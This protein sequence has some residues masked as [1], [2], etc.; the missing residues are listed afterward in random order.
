MSNFSEADSPPF[1]ITYLHGFAYRQ[2]SCMLLIP[3]LFL[4]QLLLNLPSFIFR[5]YSK[6]TGNVAPA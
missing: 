5:G 6:R 2:G 4:L 3:P 1:E